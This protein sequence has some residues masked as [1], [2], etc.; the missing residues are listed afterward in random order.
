VVKKAASHTKTALEKEQ[1]YLNG[2]MM[3][4]LHR[5]D[6]TLTMGIHHIHAEI[7]SLKQGLHKLEEKADSHT[8]NRTNS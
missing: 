3:A 2:L 6:E 4:L 7:T 8:G 5:Q 1:A